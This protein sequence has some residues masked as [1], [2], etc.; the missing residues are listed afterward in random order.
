[1]KILETKKFFDPL[2]MEWLIEV[3]ISVPSSEKITVTFADTKPKVANVGETN[4]IICK[5]K[6]KK[7]FT[8]KY[9]HVL[10]IAQQEAEN[11][12]HQIIK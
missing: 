4:Y 9:P 5:E 1:M 10:E 12:Y 7:I 11:V 8:E 6:D 2:Y 3:S